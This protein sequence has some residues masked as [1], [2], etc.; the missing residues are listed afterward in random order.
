MKNIVKLIFKHYQVALLS[1]GII[2]LSYFVG[3]V[4]GKFIF[5]GMN[6]VEIGSIFTALIFNFYLS[7]LL[8]TFT[9]VGHY[10]FKSFINDIV[11]SP[12]QNLLVLLAGSF[13]L[14]ATRL[15]EVITNNISLFNMHISLITL[16][17]F[18]LYISKS[19]LRNTFSSR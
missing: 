17:T 10:F 9:F 8:C 16:F 18:M 3:M 6:A 7:L 2:I 4:F 19:K 12:Y 15:P 13:W 11:E 5:K 14:A 1:L